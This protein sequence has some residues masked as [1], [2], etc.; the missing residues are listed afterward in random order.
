MYDIRRSQMD[1]FYDAYLDNQ[2]Y[3]YASAKWE[4]AEWKSIVKFLF[5][6]YDKKNPGL[7]WQWQ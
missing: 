6:C 4:G 2:W 7:E 5:S 1:Y 3:I